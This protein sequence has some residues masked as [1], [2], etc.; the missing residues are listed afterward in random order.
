MENIPKIKKIKNSVVN[1]PNIKDS[2]KNIIKFH[3]FSVEEN[4]ELKEFNLQFRQFSKFSQE[5]NIYQ[6]NYKHKPCKEDLLYLLF[7]LKYS[8]KELY[9]N[10]RLIM[11]CIYEPFLSQKYEY[12]NLSII[13]KNKDNNLINEHLKIFKGGIYDIKE[14]IIEN[15]KCFIVA[16]YML[17]LYLQNDFGEKNVL[18]NDFDQLITSINLIN[19]NKSMIII[20]GTKSGIIRFYQVNSFHDVKYINSIFKKFNSPINYIYSC[21]E[22][23]NINSYYFIIDDF[24][25]QLWKDFGDKILF[26]FSIEN[27]E[28]NKNKIICTDYIYNYEENENNI[29][30]ADMNFGLYLLQVKNECYFNFNKNKDIHKE[31]LELDLFKKKQITSVKFLR[32]NKNNNKYIRTLFIGNVE[33]IIIYDLFKKAINSYIPLS[34]EISFIEYYLYNSTLFLFCSGNNYLHLLHYNY[35]Q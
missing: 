18:S 10:K 21:R 9:N 5:S 19:Y 8:C 11:K 29:V 35:Q 6:I 34:D 28:N 7:S 14:C 25:V 2:L 30:Y 33:L 4:E 17:V 12:D 24:T 27:K 16:G 3:D 15:K 20:T 23:N 13:N 32:N 26:K 1:L 31:K 22:N